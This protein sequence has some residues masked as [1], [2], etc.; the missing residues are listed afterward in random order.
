MTL[1]GPA[2]PLAEALEARLRVRLL[3]A[4]QSR[5]SIDGAVAA[6]RTEI[7]T[8]RQIPDDARPSARVRRSSAISSGSIRPSQI[9][10]VQA[11]LLIIHA[12]DDREVPASQVALMRA[13]LAFSGSDAARFELVDGADHDLLVTPEGRVH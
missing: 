11:P 1:A 9:A 4:G 13:S 7:E 2:R 5:E 3:A 10:G 6:L 12:A 8:L